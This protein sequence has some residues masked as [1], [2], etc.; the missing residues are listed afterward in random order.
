M[1]S[2]SVIGIDNVWASD[3]AKDEPTIKLPDSPGPLVYAIKS[4]SFKSILLSSN[5]F[6]NTGTM[7]FMCS[8][9]AIS[10]T[11]PPY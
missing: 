7:F 5:A 2:T 3:F 8:L 9:D 10:G 6:F 11:T 4:I 1:W